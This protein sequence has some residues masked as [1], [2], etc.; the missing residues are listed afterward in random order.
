MSDLSERISQ[1]MSDPAQMAQLMEMARQF[2]LQP[3]EQPSEQPQTSPCP[4]QIQRILSVFGSSGSKEETLVS[5]LCP[6]LAPAKAEKLRRAV[7]AAKLSE[8]VTR[9][10]QEHGGS[11]NV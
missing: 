6:F 11:E 7:R 2:G 4:E 10:L 1:V 5:A 3:P 9:V 8:A